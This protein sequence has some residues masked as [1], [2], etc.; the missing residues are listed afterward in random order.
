MMLRVWNLLV[1][2]VPCVTNSANQVWVSCILWIAL[3]GG[4]IRGEALALRVILA[5]LGSRLD[6]LQVGRPKAARHGKIK[7][8]I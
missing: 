8:R 2:A 4:D 6:C 5:L 7:Q 3:K 1:V